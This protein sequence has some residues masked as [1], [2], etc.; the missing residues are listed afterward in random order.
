MVTAC[1]SLRSQASLRGEDNIVK[2]EVSNGAIG[3]AQQTI[4]KSET[5]HYY[6][7]PSMLACLDKT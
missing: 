3:L 7:L 2:M 5:G 6:V 1:F 4:K